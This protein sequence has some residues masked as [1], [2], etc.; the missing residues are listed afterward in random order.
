MRM[1]EMKDDPYIVRQGRTRWFCD[2]EADAVKQYAQCMEHITD[3][4]PSVFM[5]RI[6]NVREVTLIPARFVV[7]K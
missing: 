2:T 3:G 5:C 7:K 4:E 6:V 1:E